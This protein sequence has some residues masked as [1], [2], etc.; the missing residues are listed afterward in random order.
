MITV[1]QLLSEI[2]QQV[3]LAKQTQDEAAQR[4]AIYAVRT[5]CNVML[6]D[7]RPST[8]SIPQAMQMSSVHATPITSLNEQPLQEAD[9]N[10]E[11]LFDF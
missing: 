7:E 11:S 4:E 2:E 9:A 8:P 10:G 1:T 6:N 5:L 3:R